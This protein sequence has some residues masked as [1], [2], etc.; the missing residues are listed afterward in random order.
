MTACE[1]SS[2][3]LDSCREL[4]DREIPNF[5]RLFDNPSLV[6]ACHCLARYAALAWPATQPDGPFQS[7]LA[8]GRLEAL[9]GAVKLA[10]Y[11]LSSRGDESAGLL[12]DPVRRFPYFESIPLGAND[13]VE[14]IPGIVRAPIAPDD[15]SAFLSRRA[16]TGFLLV[17][18]PGA[19]ALTDD[20]YDS[21]DVYRRE[22]KPLTII[23]VDRDSLAAIRQPDSPRLRNWRPDVVVFDESFARCEVPFSAFSGRPSLFADWNRRGMAQFHS[24]TFQPNSI[25]SL[26]FMRSLAAFDGEFFEAEQR[27][28][29]RIER[30]WRHRM[31][32]FARLYSPSLA[33]LIRATG[34]CGKEVRA[35]GNHVYIDGRRYLDLVAGVACSVRGHSPATYLDDLTSLP[36]G[37]TCRNE[38]RRR[39][40]ELTGVDHLLPAVSGASAVEN[41]L[42]LGLASQFPKRHVL[43]LRG[44]FAGKTLLSLAATDSRKLKSRIEP[45]YEHVTFVDPFAPDALERIDETL[46]RH[47]VAIAQIELVQGVGGVRRVPA[48]V[49][50]R[51]MAA[52]ESH[53]VLLL[54]DETQTGMFRT[55]PFV[56]SHDLDL[57][58]DLLTIGKATSDMMFPFAVTMYSTD[59]RGRLLDADS[60]LPEELGRD[61]D[62]ELGF[63]TLLGTLRRAE[64]ER[65]ERRVRDSGA[66]FAAELKRE[67]AG[68]PAVRDIRAFGLLIGI[69]LASPGGASAWRTKLLAQLRLI[70]LMN[71]RPSP[72]IVGFCQFEPH[73]LKLTPPLMIDKPEIREACRTL[74]QVLRQPASRLA[75]H[76]LGALW[77]LCTT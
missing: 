42:K 65:L 29:T 27:E 64:L 14:L 60:H 22:A 15:F 8:N 7:F 46:D 67:L 2:P 34:F 24:T 17:D 74:A 21:L 75:G 1:T 26:H 45:L 9:S 39:L 63:R 47:S 70:G 62:Y 51:L 33:R 53:G 32:L 44:G 11:N 61:F 52:R 54:I 43:A 77:N 48:A 50:E 3:I 72:L 6:Q 40:C 55:G 37:D 73:V 69:E 19:L 76:G 56:M 66:F 16:G 58:P 59:I 49:V 28:L 4:I 36:R 25:A 13:A 35:A 20:Q 23:C 5:F 68:C 41:A 18:A 71:A 30:D 31:S 38:V 10:R 12:V 57:R